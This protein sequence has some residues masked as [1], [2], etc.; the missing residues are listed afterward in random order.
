MVKKVE[1]P[2]AQDSHT[3]RAY[4]DLLC[5]I[6][7]V[8]FMCLQVS[9]TVHPSTEIKLSSYPF[10]AQGISLR[11]VKTSGVRQNKVY[12]SLLSIEVKGDSF[13]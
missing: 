13:F 6:S 9:A 12:N 5:Q 7:P 4:H 1:S 8:V 11:R 10:S 3:T 2:L